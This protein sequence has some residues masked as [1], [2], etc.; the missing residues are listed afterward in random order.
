MAAPGTLVDG[1][2]RGVPQ[3]R[4]RGGALGAGRALG[5]RS[6]LVVLLLVLSSG[7]ALP[8]SPGRLSY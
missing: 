8:A 4:E 1:D 7:V 5:P 2:K 3:Q 6:L